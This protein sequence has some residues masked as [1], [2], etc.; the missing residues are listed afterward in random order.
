MT[1][2]P[3]SA[4]RNAALAAIVPTTANSESRGN[5]ITEQ[6]TAR[7]EQGERHCRKIGSRQ[8]LQDFPRLTERAMR[9]DRDTEHVTQHRYADLNPDTGEKP[10][11]NRTRE[12]ICEEP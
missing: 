1:A 3:R 11:Q 2:M 4:K 7:H 5:A 10:D 9:A 8:G 6:D 12:E